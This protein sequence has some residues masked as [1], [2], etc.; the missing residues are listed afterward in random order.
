MFSWLHEISI[1]QKSNQTALGLVPISNEQLACRTA[2]RLVTRTPEYHT[3][4]LLRELR[5]LVTAN[6]VPSSPI[7]VTLMIEAMDSSETSVPTTAT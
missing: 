5:L 4:I 2:C 3:I 1:L 6:V 7:L